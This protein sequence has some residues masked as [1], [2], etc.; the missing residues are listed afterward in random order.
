VKTIAVD[1]DG[2][3]VKYDGW[4]GACIYGA[5]IP[6]M[7]QRVHDWLRDG[8]EVI[9]FTSRVSMEFPISQIAEELKTIDVALHDM[10]LPPLF[11][12]AN[13]LSRIDEFWDDRAIGVARNTGELI[14]SVQIYS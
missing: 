4:K 12:T 9:I 11:V 7:V 8:H 6:T 13:K 1:W 14:T 5:P 2:T 10:G 3:L